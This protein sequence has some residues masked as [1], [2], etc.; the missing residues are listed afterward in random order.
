MMKRRI[1]PVRRR[2]HTAAVLALGAIIGT[3]L[4]AQPA[5]AHFVPSISHIWAHIKGK[6]DKRYLP[7]SG[8]LRSGKLIRGVYSVGHHGDVDPE[9]DWADINFRTPLASAPT[10]HFIAFGDTP[11]AQCPGSVTNPKALTGQLCVYEQTGANRSVT[12]VN[13]LNNDQGEA[14][15]FGASVFL[16]MNGSPPLQFYSRGSWAVRAP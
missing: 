2:W 10:P 9:F 7:A 16:I 15:R 1:S 8:N 4:V 5:G 3:M 11:P 6:A 14:S 12:I 13:P